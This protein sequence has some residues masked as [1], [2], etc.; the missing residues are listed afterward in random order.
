MAPEA[1]GRRALGRCVVAILL[2]DNPLGSATIGCPAKPGAKPS[3]RAAA[4]G[5]FG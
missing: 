1:I 5:P 3:F 2:E 4:P